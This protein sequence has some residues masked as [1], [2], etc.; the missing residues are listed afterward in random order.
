MIDMLI[1]SQ[2]QVNFYGWYTHMRAKTKMIWYFELKW[3]DILQ[4]AV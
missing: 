3:Y 2:Q 1:N 4:G